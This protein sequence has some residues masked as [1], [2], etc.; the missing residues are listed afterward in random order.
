M[1]YAT[2]Y[3]AAGYGGDPQ[4]HKFNASKLAGKPHVRARIG[5][6]QAQF[7][8]AGCIHAQYIQAL[9]LPIVEAD[10]RGLYE[11]VF[12]VNGEKKGEK[13]KAI[14]DLPRALASAISK[15]KVDAESGRI[16]EIALHGKVEAGNT[17]LRS[18]GGIVERHEHNVSGIAARLSAALGRIGAPDHRQVT[19][20][21]LGPVI[22]ADI[23]PVDDFEFEHAGD[24]SLPERM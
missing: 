8:E 5:E 24:E 22:D 4:W 23:V 19:S 17:L 18:V 9:L 3:A 11:P 10:V 6:L 1:P 7:E 15:I 21:D 16:T 13:L 2:A 12:G 20:S 14:S